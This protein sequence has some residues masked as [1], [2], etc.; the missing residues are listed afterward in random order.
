M[1]SA[2][3]LAQRRD[4]YESRSL[5]DAHELTDEKNLS[6]NET[7]FILEIFFNGVNPMIKGIVLSSSNVMI[8]RD[9]SSLEKWTK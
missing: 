2:Q 7:T 1:R 6:L 5:R 3:E 9:L 4:A 8:A